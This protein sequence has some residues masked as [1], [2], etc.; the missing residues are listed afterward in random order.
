MGVTRIS[1]LVSFKRMITQ[2][3]FPPLFTFAQEQHQSFLDIISFSTFE[4]F[5]NVS[6][7]PTAN[8]KMLIPSAAIFPNKI[9]PG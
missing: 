7:Y 3:I 4:I 6:S 5:S 9:S 8:I 2:K 1:L